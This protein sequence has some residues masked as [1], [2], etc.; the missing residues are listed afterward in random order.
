MKKQI[1]A[2]GPFLFLMGGLGCG[3][4]E[5][6]D[7]PGPVGHQGVEPV[8]HIETSEAPLEGGEDV[9]VGTIAKTG[10]V[11]VN[12]PGCSGTLVTPWWVLTAQ[13]CGAT[14]AGFVILGNANSVGTPRA[15]I[16]EVFDKPGFPSDGMCRPNDATLL[17]L[18]T[19]I[20]PDHVVAAPGRTWEGYRRNLYRGSMNSLLNTS[21]DIFGYGAS[22]GSGGGLGILRFATFTVDDIE[23]EYLDYNEIH[24]EATHGGDSGAGVLTPATSAGLVENYE[25]AA[26]H[27]CTTV[28]GTHQ[29][30]R[31][32]RLTAWFD[33]T[34]GS[35]WTTFDYPSRV[36]AAN[37][38]VGILR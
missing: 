19:P 6:A 10:A 17:K 38:R 8:G 31:A 27:R 25:I 2:L 32:D 14:A 15:M 35:W 3:G 16:Q 22:N 5:V 11:L 12:D 4:F 1:D 20:F 33:S 36:F 26:V 18:V 21:V 29:G 37:L 30:V 23:T 13:H 34:I 28:W 7:E 24:D 9:S